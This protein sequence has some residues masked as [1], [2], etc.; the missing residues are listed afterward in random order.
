M[1]AFGKQKSAMK[2]KSRFFNEEL[3]GDRGS[4]A[5]LDDD[6]LLLNQLNPAALDGPGAFQEDYG[7]PAQNSIFSSGNLFPNS[8]QQQR[9]LGG[10][11]AQ[12]NDHY[13]PG[14]QSL[15][16]AFG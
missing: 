7:Q 1:L 3:E 11:G 4:E 12:R 16:A 9:Q 2:N 6:D 8:Q 15:F 10:A 13:S 14:Q 5:S